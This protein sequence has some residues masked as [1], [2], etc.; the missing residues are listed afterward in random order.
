MEILIARN[1]EQID[2]AY[3]RLSAAREIACDTETSGLSAATSKLFSVQFSDGQFNVLIPVSEG[4]SLGKLSLLLE[5]PNSTTIFHNARFDLAFLQE[6]GYPVENVF[7]TM[8]AEKLLTKGAGQSASLAETLYRYFAVDLD[9][10][11]RAKFNKNWNGVW[12]DELVHYALAD[13]VYLPEL[14]RRQEEWLNKLGLSDEF[15]SQLA[16]IF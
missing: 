8:I 5:N 10:S 16:R 15:E 1:A 14:K 7:C 13:V 4:V 12:T 11:Q 6:N 2:Q 3:Q 9:K